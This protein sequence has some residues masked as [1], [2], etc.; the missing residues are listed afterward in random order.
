MRI[1]IWNAFASNNS[2]SYTIVGQFPSPELAREITIELAPLIAEHT[3]WVDAD[4]REL[5]SPLESFAIQHEL[6]LESIEEWPQYGGK[7][8]PEIIAIDHQVIIHH[9]YTATMPAA[10]GHYFYKRGGRVSVELNHSHTYIV[11]VFNVWWAWD[12]PMREKSAEL[13]EKIIEQLTSPEGTLTTTSD[14][15]VAPAWSYVQE[16]YQLSIGA[17]F[18]D[19]IAGVAGVQKVLQQYQAKANI[20]LQEARPN[21]EGPLVFLRR[22]CKT[23]EE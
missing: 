12:S 20:E 10:F 22:T 23:V 9:D 15:N 13:S 11:C 6:T 14:P 2:G 8:S 4:A 1:R 17:V 3:A 21:E 19:L 5:T 16:W 7:N 18:S